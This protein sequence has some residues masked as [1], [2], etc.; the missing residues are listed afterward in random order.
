MLIADL[1][2]QT[3]RHT[4]ISVYSN[5]SDEIV[6]WDDFVIQYSWH[7]YGIGNESKQF[8]QQCRSVAHRNQKQKQRTE[9]K[10]FAVIQPNFDLCSLSVGISFGT[11]Q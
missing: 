2:S 10:Y 3:H 6:F 5:S 8:S 7:S 4:H 9:Y 11:F 1:K